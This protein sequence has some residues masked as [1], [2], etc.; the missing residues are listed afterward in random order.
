MKERIIEAYLSK[1]THLQLDL[2][3]IAPPNNGPSTLAIAKTEERI[4]MYFPYFA[5]G[6]TIVTI[7]P[8]ME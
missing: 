1:N 2:S 7:T 4:A 6:T 5:G 3:L 8:T